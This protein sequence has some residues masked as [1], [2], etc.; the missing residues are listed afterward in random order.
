MS[1]DDSNLPKKPAKLG[2]IT[3]LWYKEVSSVRN[4][5]EK[6]FPGS[7]I[8]FDYSINNTE[9]WYPYKTFGL[10]DCSLTRADGSPL[11]Q[12]DNIA[13]N[14]GLSSNLFATGDTKINDISVSKITGYMPQ[15]DALNQR[16][17]K[18]RTWL[19]GVGSST[20]LWGANYHTRQANFTND[21]A[22]NNTAITEIYTT[23]EDLGFGETQ[24]ISISHA[25]D[26]GTGVNVC[27]LTQYV[28]TTIPFTDSFSPGD[29]IT[30]NE[31]DFKYPIITVSANT[32]TL[33]Y[34]G[35]DVVQG[36][37]P[38]SRVREPN[39]SR[40]LS[41]FSIPFV[42]AMSIFNIDHSLPVGNYK[43]SLTPQSSTSFQKFAIES[44]LG[45]GDKNPNLNSIGSPS[46]GSDFLFTVHKIVFLVA[47]GTRNPI[48]NLDYVIDLYPIE[49]NAS[50][51]QSAN[52]EHT[53]SI[54]KKTLSLTLAY[55]DSRCGFNSQISSSKFK[56]YNEDVTEAQELK[57]SSFYINYA[58]QQQPQPQ[59]DMA[60]TPGKDYTVQRYMEC[61]LNTGNYFDTGSGETIEEFQ[62]RG[63]Y[64]YFNWPR[65]HTDCSTIVKI[66][67]V[68]TNVDHKN[69]NL[70]LF[71]HKKEHVEVSI[72]GGQ[73]TSV[74]LVE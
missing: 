37:I 52:G 51:V 13:P 21:G 19:N 60:F 72:R 36:V 30:I 71:I 50:S 2:Q 73:V 48:N 29:F 53:L 68:F 9:E 67:Q 8:I 39:T 40:N 14:M 38:F 45:G 26:V 46:S 47:M 44:L 54:S 22:T 4:S 66:K 55:Q 10:M 15:I 23:K 31:V 62:E 6:S 1:F 28:D 33:N 12:V 41:Q 24:E 59:A 64:Y 58:S 56:S 32:M 25:L 27:T 16:I 7:E 63:A 49:V 69:M 42:P 43:V 20:N 3:K 11:E 70:L 18:S 57:L 74:L 5:T 17:T 34:A 61:M 35:T 65:E